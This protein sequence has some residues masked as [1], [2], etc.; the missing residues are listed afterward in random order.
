VIIEGR[1][2]IARSP[3]DVFDYLADMGNWNA[4]DKAL[5]KVSPDGPVGLGSSGT[6]THKRPGVKVK[7]SWEVTAFERAERFEILITGFGYTL[8]ETVTLTEVPTGTR[9]DTTDLTLPTSLVG[10]VMVAASGRTIQRELEVRHQRFNTL[11]ETDAGPA[12]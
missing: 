4:I 7:T 2:D 8:R 5:L 6:M 10:R 9:V 11:L 12:G 1:I 3:D